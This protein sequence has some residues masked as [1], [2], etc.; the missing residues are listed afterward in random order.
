MARLW[1][2]T[3]IPWGAFEFSMLP[4]S[5]QCTC[6]PVWSWPPAP[7]LH[8]RR[9]TKTKRNHV[10]NH[11]LP[12]WLQTTQKSCSSC[13]HEDTSNFEFATLLHVCQQETWSSN[14]Y[15]L[16]FQNL[17][18]SLKRKA[19]NNVEL[20][21]LSTI[22]HWSTSWLWVRFEDDFLMDFYDF[23]CLEIWRKYVV[24][25]FDFYRFWVPETSISAPFW[26]YFETSGPVGKLLKVL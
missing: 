21:R 17:H 20:T 15:N 2:P 14:I 26:F 13:E 19:K 11:G 22:L 8:G 9:E 18:L 10:L 24:F 3:L 7:I 23:C 5:R 16:K 25:L 4:P 1:G 12:T 6:N